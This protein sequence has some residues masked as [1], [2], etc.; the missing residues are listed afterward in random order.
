MN[1][2][3][4]SRLQVSLLFLFFLLVCAGNALA[5]DQHAAVTIYVVPAVTDEKIL[6]D[7]PMPC[8][9]TISK[10]ISMVASPGEYEPASFV[11]QANQDISSLTIATTNLTGTAGVIS[12]NNIDVRAVKCWYQ[13]GY[14]IDDTTHKHLTP[15][16]LLK[17]DSLVKAT[18]TENYLK[19]SGEYIWISGT[20]GISGIP[21]YP[22]IEEF[23]VQDSSALQPV[24]I[25]NAANKQFWVTLKVPDNCSAGTYNGVIRLKNNGALVE[26]LPLQL[27]VLP[28]VLS[29][30][31]LTYSLYHYA[32]LATTGTISHAGKNETQF[33]AEQTN[34]FN[35]GVMNPTVYYQGSDYI[36]GQVLTIR[37]AAGMSNQ[38]LY[39]LGLAIN[40]CGT[41]LDALKTA[42]SNL[43]SFVAPYGVT[44]LYIYG[45][46]EQDL[47]TSMHRAAMNAVHDAGGK[48]FCAQ[49]PSQADAVA[50]ILDLAVVAG[51][52]DVSLAD[53]YHSYG[54]EIYS[55][56]NPQVGEASPEKYRR[57]YGL[58]LWQNNYD[59]AMD[60]TY[61]AG[62]SNIWNDFDHW[63]YRD[64]N[65][66][67][68]TANGV[69]DAIQWECW[70]EGVDDARYLTVL[71]DAIAWAQSQSNDTSQAEAWL[72]DLKNSLFTAPD[73]DA[74]RSRMIGYILYHG[75]VQA[76][77]TTPH[78]VSI[79]HSP[80]YS[81]SPLSID[82]SWTTDERVTAQVEYGLTPALGSATDIDLAL[83]YAHL[84]TLTGL[85]ADTNYYVRVRSKDSAGNE[86]ISGIYSFSTK[87]T[88]TTNSYMSISFIPPTVS[89][90]AV[91]NSNWME[92]S[93]SVAGTREGS[94]FIDFNRSLAVYCNLNE[95]AGATAHDKST[96]TN[97]GTLVGMNTNTCWTNGVYGR[98]LRFDGINDYV[99]YE[100]R[101]SL[102]IT[103]A[104]TM[105]AWVK[106]EAAESTN[107]EF[108]IR[109][110]ATEPNMWTLYGMSISR[111]DRR[112]YMCLWPEGYAAGG[113]CSSTEIPL[114]EWTHVATTY[115]SATGKARIYING[116][117]DKED[118]TIF[119]GKIRTNSSPLYLGL[120]VGAGHDFNGVIDETRVW[121]RALSADE[122]YASYNAGINS[123]MDFNKSLVVCCNLNE[124]AGAT[125]HDKST[126]TNTGT[127]VGMNTN[128]CWTNGVYGR[129]LR[130]DG[131]NDYVRY[132]SRQSL[133]I[134]NAITMEAWVKPE[135]AE[136]TNYEFII[137]KTATEPNM[138]TLYGMSISR[139]DRR[140]YMCLWPEGYAAG[141]LCSSTEIP[142][143][144][145]THVATTY[146]SATGKARIYI[147]GSLDKE[148][149]TIFHGKIRTNSS[150]LYLGLHVGAGHDFNGVIDE[151]RVWSRAL[152]A[153]EIYASYKKN[154]YGD[155]GMHKFTDLIGDGRSYPYYAYYTDIT[156][157]S[158]QTET[159]TI[160]YMP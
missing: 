89:N 17:D 81:T 142:L 95:A 131:I 29:A 108:I 154:V 67:Y 39:Y 146:D 156:G 121:S 77:T 49:S 120:H 107:Y 58:W 16:L 1:G 7:S 40:S 42:V 127:L 19:V 159:R 129:A 10:T 57:N 3:I 84:F 26:E 50:D 126:Y 33:A 76:D 133:N 37:N 140:I 53:K 94:S 153:D 103:N 64:C 110:T 115:D 2:K 96:Y 150:P 52:L 54:H 128:T 151:T 93:Y 99:R 114:H 30:P 8:Q 32:N 138:W 46:D 9:H 145:W 78:V 61:Q 117:L 4:K 56:A 109:K 116:S 104:I 152:S 18:N 123:F 80:V 158:T 28:F 90:N 25:P 66:A 132:E 130:F 111:D 5:A 70:R 134:T 88:L 105:E 15:E 86:A 72:A 160:S 155:S 102:N 68:P 100:S 45:L 36:L 11:M 65:F 135:A 137:R 112:I 98:A 60:W 22:T 92:I 85:N 35:H 124:A 43:I 106:P 125:A 143:H 149:G 136:S 148:D 79:S 47:N 83:L 122:I 101:Q 73:L 63:E 24:N 119:H 157:N 23:P 74:V 27:E 71:Y 139:D 113:L 75:G 51:A 69:I 21:A 34:L 13:A 6:P 144:E 62:F 59:G 118:G 38:P 14:A 97:T 147:N 82:I 87:T 41:N 141:G 31:D 48:V 12:S 55:Y 20:N 91:I 44:E